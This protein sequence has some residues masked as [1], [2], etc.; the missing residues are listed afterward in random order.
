VRAWWLARRSAAIAAARCWARVRVRR[1]IM[2][3][4]SPQLSTGRTSVVLGPVGTDSDGK[5]R[6]PPGWVTYLSPPGEVQTT[7]PSQL[8]S[9]TGVAAPAGNS[10]EPADMGPIANRLPPTAT[11]QI[12]LRFLSAKRKFPQL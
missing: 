4:F 10:P 5:I 3:D 9:D 7:V 1:G 6:A 11:F 2:A 12:T 8:A